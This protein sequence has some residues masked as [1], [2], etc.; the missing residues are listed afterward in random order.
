LFT[1]QGIGG[2]DEEDESAGEDREGDHLRT[3]RYSNAAAPHD[4]TRI[5]TEEEK[6]RRCNGNAVEPAGWRLTIHLFC[7]GG[8]WLVE[9]FFF[10]SLKTL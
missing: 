7:S 1:G 4:N 10:L 3:T 9:K 5:W 6:K 2:A 8:S